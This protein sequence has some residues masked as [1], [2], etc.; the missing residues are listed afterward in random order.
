MM[1]RFKLAFEDDDKWVI[2]DTDDSENDFLNGEELVYV[3]NLLYSDNISLR[4]ENKRLK[5]EVT[6]LGSIIDGLVSGW[7]KY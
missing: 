4:F 7:R 5:G 3:M 1:E 6:R 2:Y